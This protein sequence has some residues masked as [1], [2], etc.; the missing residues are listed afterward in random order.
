MREE[1]ERLERKEEKEKKRSKSERPFGK[2]SLALDMLRFA[3]FLVVGD[4]T[5]Y[6]IRAKETACT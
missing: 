1:R 3:L 6:E 5:L 4:V 2:T